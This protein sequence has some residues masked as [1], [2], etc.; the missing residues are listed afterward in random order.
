[1]IRYCGLAI[2]VAVLC[3]CVRQSSD[4]IE[5]GDCRNAGRVQCQRRTDR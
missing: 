3:G 2:V 4:V 5:T 1:M